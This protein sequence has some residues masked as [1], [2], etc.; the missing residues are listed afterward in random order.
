[1]NTTLIY[2]LE[3]PF[4]KELAYRCNPI[5]TKELQRQVQELINS[6][7]IRESMS[8]CSVPALLVPKKDGAMRMYVDNIAINNLTI[9]YRYHILRLDDML[10]ELHGARVFSRIDLRSGYHQIRMRERDQWK[11]AFKTKQGLYDWL[12]MPY[13][14]YVF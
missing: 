8:L 7:Y 9:K 13:G 4:Q 14:G 11:T 5:E 2:C 12:V 6:G 1:M 3:L 10:D